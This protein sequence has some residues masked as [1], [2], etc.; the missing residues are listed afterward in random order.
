MQE[1]IPNSEPTCM[2][3]RNPDAVL[4]LKWPNHSAAEEEHFV[5]SQQ[6][7]E[8]LMEVYTTLRTILI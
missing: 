2:L 4:P 5:A 6:I 7:L 1:N 3:A 8:S